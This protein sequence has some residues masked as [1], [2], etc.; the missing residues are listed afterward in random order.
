MGD[1]AEREKDAVENTSIIKRIGCGIRE[2]SDGNQ[3]GGRQPA[4]AIKRKKEKSSSVPEAFRPTPFGTQSRR[5]KLVVAAT[6]KRDSYNVS[7]GFRDFFEQ[8]L[9]FGVV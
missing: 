7:K 3:H 5:R 9:W 4:R 2:G 1:G 8:F 6:P